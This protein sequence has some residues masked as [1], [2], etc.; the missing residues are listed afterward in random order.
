LVNEF[1]NTLKIPHNMIKLVLLQ[2]CKNDST[3][4][5]NKF[6]TVYKENEDQKSHGHLYICKNILQNLISLCGKRPEENG[7]RRNIPFNVIKVRCNKP[8]PRL[9]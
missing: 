9:E 7:N 6:N 3:L 8:I 4:E 1:N 2:A 5:I